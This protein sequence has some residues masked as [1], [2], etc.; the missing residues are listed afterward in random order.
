MIGA[1][2][3]WF[4]AAVFFGLGGNPALAFMSICLGCMFL[5]LGLSN[6]RNR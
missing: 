5:T 3:L 6:G 1:A 4:L 2:A